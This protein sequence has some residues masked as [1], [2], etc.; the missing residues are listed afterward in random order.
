MYLEVYIYQYLLVS[1]TETMTFPG[2]NGNENGNINYNMVHPEILHFIYYLGINSATNKT[3]FHYG[4]LKY[5]LNSQIEHCFKTGKYHTNENAFE[6]IKTKIGW[7]RNYCNDET[8]KYMDCHAI[9][10][11]TTIEKDT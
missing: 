8:L 7:S 10:Y 1:M 9:N 6:Y 3:Q 11:E 4:E 5:N 2:V